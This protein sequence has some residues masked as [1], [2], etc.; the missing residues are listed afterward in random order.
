MNR[1][2]AV[3]GCRV[4]QGRDHRRER[5]RERERES[6]RARE[7]ARE[8]ERHTE[9]QSYGLGRLVKHQVSKLPS[10]KPVG[11]LTLR[12][13]QVKFGAQ[14]VMARKSL[15]DKTPG[16]DM[17]DTKGLSSC[18]VSETWHL[19]AVKS[20]TFRWP[21]S[22]SPAKLPSLEDL[23]SHCSQVSHISSTWL[24]GFKIACQVAKSRRLDIP[25]QSSLSHF[26]HLAQ[27][28]LPSC[29]VSNMS[30]RLDILSQPSPS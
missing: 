4:R 2:M 17:H 19:L 5:E 14:L 12:G 7:R 20:L 8:R 22:K 10:L 3:R 27:T 30:L 16:R 6:E 21:V 15:H 28:R 18:H 29:Q 13:C 24:A 9:R 25:L 26:E 23:T 11:D 1:I